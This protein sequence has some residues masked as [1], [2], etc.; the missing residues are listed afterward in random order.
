MKIPRR[1]TLLAVLATSVLFIQ[2]A[3][4]STLTGKVIE[5]NDGDEITVF[6][7]NRPVRIRLIG[8]DAPEKDQ[9]FGEVAKLHL[10]DLVFDKYVFVEYSGIGEHTALIG[11]VLYN[12]TDIC[13]QMIRD[14]AAWYAPQ[15][16]YLTDTQKQIYSQSEQAARSEKR[17]LWQVDGAVAPWEFVKDREAKRGIAI[18]PG[19]PAPEVR[20][21]RPTP[22][23]N[24]LNLRRTNT[25]AV[26][27]PLT[28]LS[29]GFS[30]T[31]WAT[32]GPV[33]NPW[34]RL[35]PEG[36]NFSVLVPEGGKQVANEL[37]FGDQTLSLHAYVGR[38][39]YASYNVIWA[40]GPFLGETDVAATESFVSGFLTNLRLASERTGVGNSSCE[41]AGIKTVSSAGYFGREF[42]LSGCLVP[43]MARIYTKVAGD[44]RQMYFAVTLYK[45][46]DANV[47]KFV[48][49]FTL[50]QKA[51]K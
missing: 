37:P 4:A 29:G 45:E 9:A 40:T 50:K 46:A 24:N 6:N 2:Q 34:R 32:E 33:K 23:L 38:D 49:S 47:S 1:W 18:K 48:K 42:E 28:S 27:R 22:E 8:I 36:E 16:S 10:A 11:R 13:A 51:A 31:S 7:M 43:G 14:G 25:T 21:E 30:D 26:A 39:G 41:A 15:V 3:R 5:I 19:D 20:R 35:Q 12:G 44:Q 17:G